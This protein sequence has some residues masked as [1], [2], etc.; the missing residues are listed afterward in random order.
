MWPPKCRTPTQ[1]QVLHGVSVPVD[2][3]LDV[4]V[5]LKIVKNLLSTCLEFIKYTADINN[6]VLV[7]YMLKSILGTQTLSTCSTK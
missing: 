3:R 6:L 4:D 2:I 1:L 7:Y 5:K